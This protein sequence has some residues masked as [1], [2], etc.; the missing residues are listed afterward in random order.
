VNGSVDETRWKKRKNSKA[1]VEIK[2]G[3][4]DQGARVEGNGGGK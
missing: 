3:E 2:G 1:L 4:I